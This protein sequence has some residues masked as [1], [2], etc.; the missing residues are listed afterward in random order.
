MLDRP[1]IF[2]NKKKVE[3]DFNGYL[4]A[5]GIGVKKVIFIRDAT[6]D[7]K[8]I[9]IRIKQMKKRNIAEDKLKCRDC[10]ILGLR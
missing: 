7:L 2:E 1:T 3:N 8:R 9:E 5:K 4:E 10:N 6:R